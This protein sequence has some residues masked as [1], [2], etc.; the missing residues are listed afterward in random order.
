MFG[1]RRAPTVIRAAVVLLALIV[2]CSLL[3]GGTAHALIPHSHDGGEAIWQELHAVT[4]GAEMYLG[5]VFTLGSL[6]VA[7]LIFVHQLVPLHLLLASNSALERLLH[8]GVA[9]YRRF[10]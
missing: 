5:V 9:Q 10:G 2:A 6:L 8:R 7:R 4:R 1:I 3:F